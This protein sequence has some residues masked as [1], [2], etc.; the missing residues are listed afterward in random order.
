MFSSASADAMGARLSGEISFTNS[1]SKAT[2]T[3]PA[4]ATID[5]HTFDA[6]SA[7]NTSCL[8]V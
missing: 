6:K 7:G 3:T 8:S 5:F 2:R 1:Y 4:F